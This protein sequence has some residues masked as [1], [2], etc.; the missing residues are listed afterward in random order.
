MNVATVLWLREAGALP[1]ALRRTAATAVEDW[2]LGLVLSD[3]GVFVALAIAWLVADTR[4]RGLRG[5]GRWGWVVGTG[6]L[7]SPVLLVY[8]A[9]YVVGRQ[10]LEEQG[11]AGGAA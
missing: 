7:G 10:G 1:A 5:P 3:A 8:L 6:V 9:V 4:R 2:M 11:A